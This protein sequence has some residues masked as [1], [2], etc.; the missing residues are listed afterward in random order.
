MR[1]LGL[2]PTPRPRPE[3]ALDLLHAIPPHPRR[4]FQQGARHR[5]YSLRP[6]GGRRPVFLPGGYAEG[7]ERRSAHQWSV[8]PR[9]LAENAG[10]LRRSIVAIFRRRVRVSWDE[11]FSPVPVQRAPRRAV[12]V[13][14]DRVPGRPGAG[15]RAPPQAPHP[16]EA[17]SRRR[18]FAVRCRI[19]GTGPHRGSIIGTS[20][21]DAPSRARHSGDCPPIVAAV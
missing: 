1:G 14:P 9:S 21:D 6:R 7:M 8:E 17:V 10:A 4:K 20:R 2:L 11:A 5:P 12:V 3:R 16:P 15:S 18:S 19:S 13:P